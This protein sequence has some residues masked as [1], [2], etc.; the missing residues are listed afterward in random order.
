MFD[1][2]IYI[3]IHIHHDP[4]CISSQ[5]SRV[6]SWRQLRTRVFLGWMT[7]RKNLSAVQNTSKLQRKMCLKWDLRN[8]CAYLRSN[9]AY[10]RKTRPIHTYKKSRGF[11]RLPELF[12]GSISVTREKLA[13]GIFL[14]K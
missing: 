11:W 14:K 7:K 6:V 13:E 9:Q 2:Y 4:G 5:L 1:I 3:Y 8:R 12:A 10:T